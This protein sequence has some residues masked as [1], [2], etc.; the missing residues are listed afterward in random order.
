MN[1]KKLIAYICIFL[2]ILIVGISSFVYIGVKMNEGK[3]DIT[4]YTVIN[5][6]IPTEFNDFKIVQLSDFHSKGYRGTT[7]NIIEEIKNINPDIVVMTG[8]MISWDIKNIEELEKLIK[9]LAIIFP[10]YYINGNHEQLA[11][12]LNTEKYERFINEIR[13]LG[14]ITINDSFIQVT[15]GIESINLYEIDIPLDEAKG[16]YIDESKINENYVENTLGIIDLTK[17]NILLAHNPLCIDEYSEWGADLVLSG[18]MHGGIVRIPFINKGIMSPEKRIF[19]KYDAGEFE[20][21]N[22]IMIINRGIGASSFELRV[23]NNPEI[24]VIKLKHKQ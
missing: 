13:Q 19:P 5:E 12:I 18:H 9:E 7:D 14:V 11:E 1:K 15:K 24:T 2:V 10:V 16:I 6:K 23:F 4:E 3:I 20:V 8:D 22:T 17:F 21:G